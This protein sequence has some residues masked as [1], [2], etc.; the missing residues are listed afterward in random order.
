MKS[1]FLKTLVLIFSGPLA[2]LLLGVFGLVLAPPNQ[3][4]SSFGYYPICGLALPISI[5]LFIRHKLLGWKFWS[6]IVAS[7]FILIIFFLTVLSAMSML[8]S[9]MSTCNLIETTNTTVRYECV[10]SSSDDGTYHR[11][12]MIVGFKGWPIM[13]A[14]N[15]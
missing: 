2:A 15:K 5:A 1:E 4:F 8:P 14:I 6:A 13:R 9:A 10:D 7:T 3:G 12:F 11:E